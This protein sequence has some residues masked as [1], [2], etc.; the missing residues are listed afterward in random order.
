MN[1]N[2]YYK[3]S[4]PAKNYFFHNFLNV[5]FLELWDHRIRELEWRIRLNIFSP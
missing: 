2:A 4:K 3:N 5:T 1:L